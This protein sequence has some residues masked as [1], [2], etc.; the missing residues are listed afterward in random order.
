MTAVCKTSFADFV[1]SLRTAD[2]S[3]DKNLRTAVTSFLTT[4]SG[5]RVEGLGE[6]SGVKVQGLGEISGVKVEGLGEISRVKVQGLGVREDSA[7][8][9]LA[10]GEASCI[11]P[12]CPEGTSWGAEPK[13]ESRTPAGFLRRK[14]T[15]EPSELKTGVAAFTAWLHAMTARGLADSYILR[16]LRALN[17][18]HKAVTGAQSAELSALIATLAGGAN[19][20]APLHR[21]LAHLQHLAATL[22]ARSPYSKGQSDFYGEAQPPYSPAMGKEATQSTPSPYSYPDS[23]YRAVILASVLLPD[24]PLERLIALKAGDDLPNIPQLH[25]LVALFRSK[26]RKYLF[27]LGQTTTRPETILRRLLAEASKEFRVQG[28]GVREESAEL[29]SKPQCLSTGCKAAH[30]AEPV[31]KPQYLSTGCNAAHSAEPVSKPQCLSTGCKAA[32]SSVSTDSF[33]TLRRSLWHTALL[34]SGSAGSPYS[35]EQSDFYGEA[36]PPYSPAMGKEATQSTPS[37]YSYPALSLRSLRRVASYLIPDYRRWYAMGLR[38]RVTPD[39]VTDRL[40]DLGISLETFYP[41]AEKRV[42]KKLKKKLTPY[43]SRVLFFKARPGQLD[44]LFGKIGDIAWGYRQTKEAGSPYA[45]IADMNNFKRCIQA[46][47]P[48]TDIDILD[49][50]A[51]ERLRALSCGQRVLITGGPWSGYEGTVLKTATP[52]HYHLVITLCNVS[53]DTTVTLAPQYLEVISD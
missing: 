1:E 14:Q 19:P 36:Q 45:V 5:V 20:A 35:K 24:W 22:S 30:S 13:A 37:P 41:L 38:P 39:T 25:D 7:S 46:L 53:F 52:D 9:C 29:V 28:L 3:A 40:D 31:S 15:E 12:G 2:F 50:A 27:P 51:L 48:Q 34:L 11:T 33:D 26:R 6:I 16:N 10:G 47:D 23:A 8:A 18:A 49:D 17:A 32:K 43:I 21:S 42:G 4:L 44:R